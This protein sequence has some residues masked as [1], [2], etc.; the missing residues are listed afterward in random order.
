MRH[1]IKVNDIIENLLITTTSKI[2]LKSSISE[3][4]KRYMTYY[5]CVCIRCGDTAIL[6]K[7][8]LSKGFY[9]TCKKKERKKNRTIKPTDKLYYIWQNIKKRCY[10]PNNKSYKQYGNKGITVYGKWLASYEEFKKWSINNGYRQGL[11]I[12]RINNNEGYT[13]TNCK[14]LKNIK[15]NNNRSNN[16]F[17]TWKGET[18]TIAEW[19]RKLGYCHNSLRSIIRKSNK[20]IEEIITNTI[21][22]KLRNKDKH[23]SK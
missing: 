10:N 9:C 1:K 7:N 14:W 12:S 4:P 23:V 22:R 13:P 6:R 11:S 16:H 5:N 17:I 3:N 19:E 8:R 21:S 18:K 2:L 15:Q 20:P